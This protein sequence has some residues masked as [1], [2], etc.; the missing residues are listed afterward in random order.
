MPDLRSAEWYNTTMEFEN[1]SPAADASVDNTVS[2]A[3]WLAVAAAVAMMACLC[4]L[5]AGSILVSAGVATY[6]GLSGVAI[7]E[8]AAT[9]PTYTPLPTY[10]PPPTYTPLPTYTPPAAEM[11][12]PGPDATSLSPAETETVSTP[13]PADDGAYPGFGEGL[14][15][16]TEDADYTVEVGD[17]L[18]SISQRFGV[19]VIPIAFVNN[20]DPQNPQLTPGTQLIIPARLSDF[21][22]PP[23]E[24]VSAEVTR[25]LGGDLIEV[26]IG[27]QVFTIRYIGVSAP[28]TAPSAEP[29]AEEAL[30]ANRQL[31]EGKT[32]ELLEDVTNA[33]N[34]GVLPRYVLLDNRLINYEI[35]RQGLGR[36]APTPPDV[37]CEDLFQMAAEQA[38]RERAGL[39][40][41][42]G[43]PPPAVLATQSG[44]P[45][46]TPFAS[47]WMPPPT[48]T[49]TPTS[50]L[51]FNCH[52]AGKNRVWGNFYNLAQGEVCQAICRI[53]AE[54]E[55]AACATAMVVSG[56]A[57]GCR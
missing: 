15:A 3:S 2:R 34:A 4:G 17:S 19:D 32:V 57:I 11:P 40:A 1:P 43:T 47:G 41:D 21:C 44:G 49:A 33:D 37:A 12:Y 18:E 29:F 9:G 52:C 39:W 48:Q 20:L 56:G 51:G 14:P 10:T 31:V 6:A 22:V 46:A 28:K 13:Y 7:T 8:V 55:A 38:R 36:S 50:S 30:E 42:A 35:A 24:P 54:R 25:V 5:A 45:A 23:N 26:S 27:G 53:Q 16:L